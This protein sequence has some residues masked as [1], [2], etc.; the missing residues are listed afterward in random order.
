MWL[1]FVGFFVPETRVG[2]FKIP[3]LKCPLLTPCGLTWSGLGLHCRQSGG[4]GKDCSALP[5]CPSRRA[6]RQLNLPSWQPISWV[7][8]VN[9]FGWMLITLL[10]PQN[11]Q[12]LCRQKAMMFE[13]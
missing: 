5:P 7:I 4:G 6:A 3:W 13:G 1:C 8:H 11:L 10:L 12:I 9:L 2:K